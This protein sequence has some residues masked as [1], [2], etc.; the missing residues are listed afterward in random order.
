MNYYYNPPRGSRARKAL[1]GAG[2]LGFL[3]K[4][5][6]KTVGKWGKRRITDLKD[7]RKEI[8]SL[9]AAVKA[10]NQNQNGAGFDL[11]EKIDNLGRKQ[12]NAGHRRGK[13]KAKG[14]CAA[15][16][17]YFASRDKGGSTLMGVRYCD[18][19][20]QRRKREKMREMMQQELEK[21]RKRRELQKKWAV[22]PQFE[23]EDYW[24]RKLKGKSL[25]D[26]VLE[27][28]QKNPPPL[29]T[30]QGGKLEGRDVIDFLAGPIGWAF[31]G[32][33]KSREKKIDKLKKQLNGGM[34]GH[35]AKVYLPLE[36][37]AYSPYK[38]APKL[39]LAIDGY[40]PQQQATLLM[41][42]DEFNR[43]DDNQ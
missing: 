34:I 40:K 39:S 22:D 18:T 9:E 11:F 4:L 30:Y 37:P 7:Q 12:S 8:K 32:V 10:K 19:A 24:K 33:R 21:V 43:R 28:G 1:D 20:A 17:R 6:A 2:L 27:H 29:S 38:L 31:M 42:M 26:L 16:K 25:K 13:V 3:G 23:E 41:T 35:D 15:C 5:Y 36:T 14:G